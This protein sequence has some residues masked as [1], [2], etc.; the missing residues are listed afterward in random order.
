VT[1][2]NTTFY[3]N[4]AA[5]GNTTYGGTAAAGGNGSGL[6]G[7]I[8]NYAGTVQLSFVTMAENSTS[9]GS[10]GAGGNADGGAIYSYA[11]ANCGTI[12]GNVCNGGNADLSLA[13]TIAARSVGSSH[14]VV[15]DAS[16]GTATSGGAGNLIVAQSGFAGSS[17]SSDPKLGALSPYAASGAPATLP[18]SAASPAYNAAASCN[19]A[20][21]QAIATDARGR[22]RPQ[23][24]LCDIGAYEYDGDYIFANSY[25]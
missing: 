17:I 6:G 2:I 24:G 12:D 21:N 4:S 22:A 20:K 16:A 7:A 19:D 14:D 5:G 3:R 10:G 13:N 1:A 8:F 11:D 15:I 18:I 23:A 25:E 9:T